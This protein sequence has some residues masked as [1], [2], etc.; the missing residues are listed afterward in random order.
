MKIK[1]DVQFPTPVWLKRAVLVALP[2]ALVV[3]SSVVLADVPNT[4]KDG[5]T[6]SAQKLND[7][8]DAVDKRLAAIESKANVVTKNGKSISTAATFC[9]TSAA[10]QTG[11]LGGYV[12]AKALCENIAACNSPTA[13]V[14][15]GEELMRSTT[16]GISLPD[17]GRYASGEAYANDCGGF[18]LG[19]GVN[20]P[21]WTKVGPHLLSCGTLLPVLCCD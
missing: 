3:A 13:H 5:D 17:D 19:N 11:D 9:G 20:G 8:F 15:T 10:P 4:F 14:C 18:N 12:A 6:L 21:V 2:V 1:V 7:N 16:L